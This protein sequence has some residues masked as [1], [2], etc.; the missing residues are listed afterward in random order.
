M[1]EVIFGKA[2]RLFLATLLKKYKSSYVFFLK[3]NYLK[4]QVC[5]TTFS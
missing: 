4:E 2:A 1:E 3:S 5:D